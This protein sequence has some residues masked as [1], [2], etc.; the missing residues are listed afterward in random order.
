MVEQQK[1]IE[2][3]AKPKEEVKR[4]EP[5]KPHNPA[6][7]GPLGVNAKGEGPA[8]AFGLVGQ[9]GGSGLVGDGGGGSGGRW[10][11]YASQVQTRIEEALRNNQ[12]TRGSKMNLQVQI[13]PD[14]AGRIVRVQLTGSTGDPTIDRAITNEV[15]SG[16]QLQEPPPAEMPVPI[17]LRLTARRPD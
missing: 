17:V 13:W 7:S 1:M 15:L 8:D 16:L 6:P 3:E 12:H 4:D 9:P 2:P 5:P 10:G 11:W 14:K